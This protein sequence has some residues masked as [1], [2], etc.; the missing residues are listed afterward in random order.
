MAAAA[1]AA[2]LE[3][4]PIQGKPSKRH[5]WTVG[6]LFS[7]Q[8]RLTLLMTIFAWVGLRKRWP[9]YSLI[10]PGQ[11]IFRVHQVDL[12]PPWG[13]HRDALREKARDKEEWNLVFHQLQF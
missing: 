13:R 11:R 2:A 12:S 8:N 1:A 5:C 6:C 10:R 7:L 3:L 4:E 9:N